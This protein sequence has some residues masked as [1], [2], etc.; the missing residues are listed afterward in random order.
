VQRRHL[1]ADPQAA[2][3]WRET[4]KLRHDPRV[5][6]CLGNVLR[7]ASLDEL[8]QL[9]N[10]LRGEM[11]LVGPRP[12]VPEEIERYGRHARACFQ[13]RPGHTGMWQVGGRNRASYS[14]RIAR[15][16]YFA[17]NWS[18]WLDN[19][20]APRVSTRTRAV[21]V[22]TGKGR[23]SFSVV[24]PPHDHRLETRFASVIVASCSYA[25]AISS[26]TCLSVE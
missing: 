2:E 5:G 9:I 21:V 14:A 6:G 10:V 8:P 18:L 26:K 12:V 4:R 22:L 11:S 19:R 1:A 7:K 24:A 16:L 3:E 13:A 20:R 15:D 23:E 25:A 17:R